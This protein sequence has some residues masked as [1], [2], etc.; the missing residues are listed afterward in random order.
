MR[1]SKEAHLRQT[2]LIQ[3][4]STT[5]VGIRD[6][7]SF[8]VKLECAGGRVGTVEDRVAHS[9]VLEREVDLERRVGEEK[10]RVP[11]RRR[12]GAPMAGMFKELI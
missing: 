4:H 3:I 1:T 11:F 8:W 9:K 5:V 6:S 7:V 2:S 10:E 12:G